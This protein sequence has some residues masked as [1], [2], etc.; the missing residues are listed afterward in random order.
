[1]ELIT[2]TVVLIATVVA[3]II[4]YATLPD[5]DKEKLHLF[6]DRSWR[7]SLAGALLAL[8]MVSV[9]A[10]WLWSIF[11][12]IGFFTRSAELTRLEIANFVFS[13]PIA[14]IYI[15]WIFIGKYRRAF[16]KWRSEELDKFN[17]KKLEQNKNSS[18][19]NPNKDKVDD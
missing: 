17:K 8:I 3:L 5:K 1:M 10:L 2:Q 13:V 9:A 7:R 4:K 18:N 12:V 16:L 19:Q 11:S 14:A 15:D 6:L